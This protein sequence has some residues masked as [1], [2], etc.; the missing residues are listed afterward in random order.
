MGQSKKFFS[1]VGILLL[2]LLISRCSWISN[3]GSSAELKQTTVTDH[4]STPV[5]HSPEPQTT[6]IP[7]TTPFTDTPV[8]P[9]TPIP[10]NPTE[11]LPADPIKLAWFYKPPSNGDLMTVG[12]LFDFFIL[13]H[14]DEFERDILRSDGVSTPILQYLLLIEIQDPGECNKEPYGNQVAYLVGDYCSLINEHPD[15]FMRGLDGQII[16]N[17]KTVYMDPGNPEYRSFWLERARNSQVTLGWNGVFIDN[18][19]ASLEASRQRNLVPERYADD[20]SYQ[21]A[22]T[23]F[24]EFLYTN[25]FHPQGRPMMANITALN[26]P[27][28]W[29]RYLDY[30]DGVMIEA[31]A[32]DWHD[33]YRSVDNWEK[34][35]AM[36]EETQSL[37]KSVILVAQGHREDTDRQLFALASYLLVNN[38]L[39]Y[40]RY[41][42]YDLY[43]EIWNYDN[44]SLDLGA[45]LGS[46]YQTAGLVKRDFANGFVQVDPEKHTAQIQIRK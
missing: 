6:P 11:A 29:F 1:L 10:A 18:V 40:F 32:V 23:G 8:H 42:D 43:D 36:V 12:N 4:V 26:D 20:A 28:T 16:R 2:P 24:L 44:Y 7:E 22:I 30:L 5:T 38:G 27:K 15:W 9:T 3:N 14:K 25:Y 41:A 13:T 34:Q 31:F 17:G 19:E 37:G 45:P 35:L 46:R 39:A 33:G 21:D